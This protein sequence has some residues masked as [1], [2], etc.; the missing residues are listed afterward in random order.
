MRVIWNQEPGGERVLALGTFDGVHRGHQ[1]LIAAG[2]AYARERGIL[3]RVSTFDRHPLEVLCPERTPRMLT[4]Q[5]EKVIWIHRYGADETQILPFTRKTAEMEP[6]DFLRQLRETIRLRAVAAGWNYTF[7]RGGRG[8][9]EML[10]EDGEKH[11]YEVLIVPPVKTEDGEIISSTLIRDRLRESRIGEARE[12]LGHDFHPG[13]VF[14]G[15]AEILREWTEWSK[16]G[17]SADLH[18]PEP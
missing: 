6:E 11:G 15:D 10:R 17:H 16:I 12:M 2:K 5:R 4:T 8:N 7:G 18:E 13:R 9:A 3:L 1:A 14:R